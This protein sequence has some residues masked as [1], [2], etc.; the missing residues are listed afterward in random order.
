MRLRLE[1]THG[2]W[3]AEVSVGPVPITAKKACLFPNGPVKQSCVMESAPALTA[4]ERSAIPTDAR[5]LSTRWSCPTIVFAATCILVGI[6]WDISWHSTI[7]RDTFWTPAHICIHLGGT[8]GG[9]VC[10]WLVLRASFFGTAEDRAASVKVWGFRGP[11]GAWVTIWGALAMLTSA[12]FD[13]WWHDAYGLDVEILSPPHSVL[14]AGMY[15]HVVGGLLLVLSLQNRSAEAQQS[16]G[17]WLFAFAGGILVCLAAIMMTEK[18][19]PNQQHS[20]SFYRMACGV[21]PF[22]L[23]ALGRASKLAWPAT[24]IAGIYMALMCAAVWILPLFPAE[25]KLAPIFNPVK[26]MVPPAF[27]L[28]L[29]VPAFAMDLAF[30]GIGR[31]RGWKRDL[32]LAAALG[33]AFTV[34]FVITQWEFSKVLISPDAKNWFFNGSG[35]FTFADTP[36]EHWH[37]FWRLDS[38]PVTTRAL[39]NAWL[40]AVIASAL[41]VAAGNWMSKV[42]R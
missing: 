6:V 39:F 1:N 36:G 11:L 26:H 9:L 37:R 12:P 38:D 32:L 33:T 20:A 17:R 14:A 5:T 35:F 16:R 41:G 30:R 25:P 4:F 22:L 7:G 42:K 23:V 34:L 29:I 28:L 18:S 3:R 15:F 13:N 27:P 8:L 40:V 10:G 2:F 21:F 19:L 31:G 24:T